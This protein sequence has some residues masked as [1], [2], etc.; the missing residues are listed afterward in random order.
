MVAA[1]GS[2]LFD[3]TGKLAVVT[4]GAN[5]LGRMIAEGLLHAGASVVITSRKADACR[6]AEA[7][8]AVLGAC[9]AI[10][11]DFSEPAGADDFATRF[12]ARHDGLHLLVNNAGKTWGAPLED[13]PDKAWPSVMAI[14]VQVP[15]KLIQCL[16]PMLER[17]ARPGDPAR[18]VNVGSVAGL[19]VEPLRAYSYSASK[20]A[21]HQ[22]GSQLAGELAPRNITVN[23]LVPGYFPTTMTGHLKDSDGAPAGMLAGRIPLGR[24]GDAADIAG[25]VQFLASRAG[26]YV[27]GSQLVVDGGLSGC[28]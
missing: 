9:Q 1:D 26:A 13:F 23:T 19:V 11:A 28:R 17:A 16:L 21:L 24:F 12:G 6:Q 25:A 8:M 22:L 14:N 27:T 10:Q 7:E 18:I 2:H 5:G 4:G 3:L 20:A 15:F